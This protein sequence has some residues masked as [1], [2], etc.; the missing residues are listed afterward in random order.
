MGTLFGSWQDMVQTISCALARSSREGSLLDR[1]IEDVVCRV[2][3]CCVWVEVVDCTMAAVEDI[4][5]EEEVVAE[6]VVDEVVQLVVVQN[7][8]VEVQQIEGWNC[9]G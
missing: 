9:L 8:V 2:G 1:Q 6:S 7:V 5:V 4:G 3:S